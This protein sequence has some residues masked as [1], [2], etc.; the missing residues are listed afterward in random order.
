MR[1]KKY[2]TFSSFL[3]KKIFCHQKRHLYACKLILLIILET[4]DTGAEKAQTILDDFD[5]LFDKSFLIRNCFIVIQKNALPLAWFWEKNQIFI[6]LDSDYNFSLQLI[7]HSFENIFTWSIS[8]FLWFI[9]TK[10]YDQMIYA[11]HEI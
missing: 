11:P 5:T 3:S 1:L 7:G 8:T 4:S 10:K 9:C 2:V 6:F